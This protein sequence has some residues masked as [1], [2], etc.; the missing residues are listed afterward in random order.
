MKTEP[1]P[2]NSLLEL[3]QELNT[4]FR[5]KKRKKSQHSS[6]RT[7]KAHSYDFNEPIELRY[8]Q[9]YYA[10]SS[11]PV[12]FGSAHSSSQGIT[13]PL[14]FGS[15]LNSSTAMYYV[16]PFEDNGPAV[17]LQPTE[18]L[19]DTPA[20]PPVSTEILLKA[21][22]QPMNPLN[23]V[24]APAISP[25]V[26]SAQPSPP[27][28]W[29]NLE[30]K[31]SPNSNQEQ[32]L[33]VDDH[34]SAF[35][36][37][38]RSVINRQQPIGTAHPQAGQ[39]TPPAST[40]L[41]GTSSQTAPLPPELEGPHA[42]FDQMG[43][44]LAYATTYN[45][46][47]VAL[48][49]RFDTFDESIPTVPPKLVLPG[50]VTSPAATPTMPGLDRMDMIEDFSYMSQAVSASTLSGASW[51]SQFP[52]STS[53]DDLDPEFRDKVKAFIAALS[54]AGGSYQINATR[55]P[56]ERAYLM[57]WAWNIA[58]QNTDVSTAPAMLG[59]NINWNHGSQEKSRQAAQEMV[60][61]YGIQNLDVAPSLGSRHI[62]GKAVDMEVSWMGD[63]S[64]KT[65]DGS[66][67]VI[68]SEP[69]NHTNTDL[70]DVAKTYGVIHFINISKDKVHW[71]TDGR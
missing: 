4:P 66:T 35:M 55:R 34:A 40:P 59:V 31:L 33:A 14:E 16:E 67:Q 22:P 60:N 44:G 21:V 54:V 51:V 15:T 62:Y 49:E 23:S 45:L 43:A 48:E 42:I 61:A 36:D 26:P 20:V 9:S 46:G 8:N 28:D 25:G 30:S 11:R 6:P 2:R 12:P 29:E 53:L 5:Q 7:A 39:P 70:I 71:S 38:L 3:E 64:I 69:R 50:A 1:L 24:I 41:P 19:L 52:T 27:F 10:H 63:L 17:V 37:E 65:V 47:P 58:K 56:K 32:P 68:S 57:H 18:T 13:L